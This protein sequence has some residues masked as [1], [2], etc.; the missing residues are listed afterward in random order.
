MRVILLSLVVCGGLVFLGS[1]LEPAESAPQGPRHFELIAETG[2]HFSF[3][4]SP[5][6]NDAGGVVFRAG[7]NPSGEAIYKSRAKSRTGSLT[8]IAD[9]SGP[10]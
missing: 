4:V 1:T 5:S 3:L 8:L 6:V 9:T 2:R 10:I 7:L